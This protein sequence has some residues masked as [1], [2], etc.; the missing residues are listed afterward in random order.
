[1]SFSHVAQIYYFY[2]ASFLYNLI[3]SFN[4]SFEWLD[5]NENIFINITGI[6]HKRNINNP[7]IDRQNKIALAED[8]L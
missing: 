2:Y 3:H 7:F 5:L 8:I 6:H 4:C 1:M